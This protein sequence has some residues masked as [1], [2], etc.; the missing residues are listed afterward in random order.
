MLYLGIDQ[1]KAQLTINLRNEGGDI[2]LQQQVVTDHAKIDDF[3][4]SL[5][6]Q[7]SRTKGFM[8][9]LEVCGFNHGLLKKL[10]EYGFSRV[11]GDALVCGRAVLRGRAAVTDRVI[12]KDNALL[13]D[14]A[15]AY[16]DALIGESSFI[17]GVATIYGNAKIL[18]NSY[19]GTRR[20]PTYSVM[21]LSGR[22]P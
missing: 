11:S 15:F 19:Y 6:K 4:A 14:H 17:S 9:I 10:E 12:V 18:C 8:A 5:K 1:Y 7:S 13:N 21:V 2:I 3:F 20:R 16:G 22:T